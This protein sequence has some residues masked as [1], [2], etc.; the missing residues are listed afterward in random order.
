[1]MFL[2][3]GKIMSE[4]LPIDGPAGRQE[5]SEAYRDHYDAI[6]KPK[7]SKTDGGNENVK[8]DSEHRT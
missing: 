1:M 4:K 6:F 7:K 3:G 2:N 8:K 5:V